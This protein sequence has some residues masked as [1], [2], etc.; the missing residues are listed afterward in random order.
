MVLDP[1]GASPPALATGVRGAS[2]DRRGNDRQGGGGNVDSQRQDR[3]QSWRQDSV[4]TRD[5]RTHRPRPI[6]AFPS[7]QQLVTPARLRP[8]IWLDLP[9]VRPQDERRLTVLTPRVTPLKENR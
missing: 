3:V 9:H 1:L 7:P 5:L 2:V 4:K 6:C 8:S